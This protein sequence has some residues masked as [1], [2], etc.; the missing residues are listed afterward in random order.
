[1]AQATSDNFQDGLTTD[2]LSIVSMYVTL[3]VTA[4][5]FPKIHNNQL[6][7][8]RRSIRDGSRPMDHTEH[9]TGNLVGL[10]ALTFFSK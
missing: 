7:T 9:E 10:Y 2:R 1:M 6:V 5:T 8:Q 4:L 3:D